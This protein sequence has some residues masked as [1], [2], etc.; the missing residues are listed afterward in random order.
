MVS[1]V[2][3]IIINNNN[4]YSSSNLRAI[5]IKKEYFVSNKFTMHTQKHYR[6]YKNQFMCLTTIL[7]NCP[8]LSTLTNYCWDTILTR[9]TSTKLQSPNT[10]FRNSLKFPLTHGMTGTLNCIS[11]LRAELGTIL[12]LASSQNTFFLPQVVNYSTSKMNAFL[13]AILVTDD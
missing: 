7:R 2:T 3:T 10:S 11:T 1:G 8:I 12:P 9:Q 6:N 4:F 5:G 13:Y